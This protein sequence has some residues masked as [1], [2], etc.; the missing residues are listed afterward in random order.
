MGGRESFAQLFPWEGEK[1]WKGDGLNFRHDG[2][3]GERAHHYYTTISH[4]GVQ[5][6]RDIQNRIL[7]Y[8]H[9]NYPF[10]IIRSEMDSILRVA[11]KDFRVKYEADVFLHGYL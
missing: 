1:S 7:R 9:H 5:T 11:Y 2:G 6:S 8:I 10:R 4:N 3:S